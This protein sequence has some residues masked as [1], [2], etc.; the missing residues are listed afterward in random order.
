[1]TKRALTETELIAASKAQYMSKAQQEF[2]EQRLLTLRSELL[3]NMRD[4]TKHLHATEAA[5]DSSDRATQEEEHTLLLTRDRERKLLK[6]IDEALA[7]IAAGT[8]GFCEDTGEPIGIR[9]LLARPTATLSVEA[10][11][12]RER[13]Q[14]QFADSLAEQSNNLAR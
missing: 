5:S 7:R 1:M 3:E 9:R 8:Y 12:K 4:T 11:D 14:R 13:M 6:K 2:F 10:Q